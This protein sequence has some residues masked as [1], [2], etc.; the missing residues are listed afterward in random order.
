[1]KRAGTQ[2]VGEP[3]RGLEHDHR[4][5]L[6]RERERDEE[7]D[8][9]GA[10]DDDAIVEIHFPCDCRILDGAGTARRQHAP[11]GRAGCWQSR[12]SPSR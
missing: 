1:M 3:G 8:R 2:V 12:R 5:V 7:P 6:P 9:P 4:N 10:G 11:P